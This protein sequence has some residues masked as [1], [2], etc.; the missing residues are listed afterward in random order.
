LDT[1]EVDRFPGEKPSLYHLMRSRKRQEQLHINNITDKHGIRHV[2]NRYIMRKITHFLQTKYEAIDVDMGE[3][4][5][6]GQSI[7]TKLHP[8]TNIVLVENVTM[9]ELEDAVKA[10]KNRKAPGSDGICQEFFKANWTTIQHEMLDVIQRMHNKG[11]LTQQQK[12]GVIV[13]LTKSP[14]PECPEDYRPLTLLN[15]DLKLQ[16][17]IIAKR[18]APWLPQILHPGQHCG[19]RGKSILEATTTLRDAIAYTE[20]LNKRLCILSLD[21]QEA[22]DRISHTYLYR[23]LGAHGFSDRFIGQIRSLYE[24]TTASVQINGYRSNPIPIRSSIRQGCPLSVLLYALCLN[25]LLCMIDK[26]T[27]GIRVDARSARIAIVAYADD[28]NILLTTPDEVR[29]VQQAI[30]SYQR[31]S[32]ARINLAKSKA[33]AQ[34]GWDTTTNV[35]GIQYRDELKILGIIF[36]RTTAQTIAHNWA[37]RMRSIKKQASEVYCRDLRLNHR[38]RYVHEYLLAR[39]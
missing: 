4:T 33:L 5:N 17:R 1:D 38:I 19:V 11:G 15:T 39:A 28:V 18:L 8:D 24:G 6:M 37:L 32:G 13:C 14:Q 12:H 29:A 21:F 20:T 35:M 10:G 16:A 26:V 25:P 3:V 34:G 2:T 31:A 7:P 30:E 22:F 23:I 27:K 9:E 36:H